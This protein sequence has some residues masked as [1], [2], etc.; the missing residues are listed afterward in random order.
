MTSPQ[1]AF[2][3][4][5]RGAVLDWAVL[6]LLVIVWGSAFAALK[7]AAVSF[8]A[9]WMVAV[10]LGVSALTLGLIVGFQRKAL[11]GVLPRPSGLWLW[12]GAVGVF[13]MAFP[14]LGFAWAA[15]HVDSAVLAIL[16]GAAPLFTALLAHFTLEGE[17]MGWRRALGLSFGFLGLAVLIGPKLNLGGEGAFG[18]AFL[19][20][21]AGVFATLGYAF[22][23]VVTKIA[24]K[25]DAT[26]TACVFSFAGAAVAIVA[27]LLIL[28]FPTG[29]SLASWGAVIFLGV[30][31]TALAT[32]LYVWLIQRRGPVFTAMTTYLT[33]LWAT[34]LGITFLGEA[35]TVPIFAS[36][37]LI[38][39]G[40]W[41]ANARAR[42]AGTPR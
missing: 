25:G 11:P 19:A 18:L 37:G 40:V 34:V 3:N 1:Q 30:F 2:S 22:G 13:G 42:P 39:L 38:L 6:L 16:N 31:P 23:N 20:C 26:V 9:F 12:W 17:K 8:D 36:L 32:I 28:P 5:F 29:I 7:I 15:R 21:L 41:I 27:A 24:P 14:F 10:R 35:L 33:P 4:P